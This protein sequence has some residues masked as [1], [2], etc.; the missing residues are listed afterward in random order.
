MSKKNLVISIGNH[1]FDELQ[2]EAMKNNLSTH[3]QTKKIIQD[4]LRRKRAKIQ[5]KT[6]S[7]NRH[8]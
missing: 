6:I 3:D 7:G 8:S 2:Q 5:R 4:F 1:E